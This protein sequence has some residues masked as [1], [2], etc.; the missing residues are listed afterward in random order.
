MNVSLSKCFVVGFMFSDLLFSKV[1]PITPPNKAN[2]WDIFSS[3]MVWKRW[4]FYDL[5]RYGN[6]WYLYVSMIYVKFVVG[7]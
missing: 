7:K 6:F 2:S 1:I 4:V 5:F 3:M